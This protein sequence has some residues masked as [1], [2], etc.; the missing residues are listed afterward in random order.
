MANP[1]HPI[2]VT[3]DL[4]GVHY[5]TVPSFKT[6]MAFLRGRGTLPQIVNEIKPYMPPTG[7]YNRG[8]ARLSY[9]VHRYRPFYPDG[10]SG[11]KKFKETG[12]LYSR[13]LLFAALSGREIDKHEMTKRSLLKAGY[14]DYI[15]EWMLNKG[16]SATAWKE[17]QIR[18]KVNEG[19]TVVHLEDDT[20]TACCVA[21]VND[22]FAGETRVIVY[23]LSNLT[24]KPWLLRKAGIKL[25][26]NIILVNNLYEASEHFEK[27]VSTGVI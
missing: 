4:D 17:K 21:R 18:T 15:T 5:V 13:T 9:I 24:N 26:S 11:L 20:K 14:G 3:N 25:P 23:L 22:E 27:L 1:E 2:L 10:L 16:T 12:K 8:L 7:I 6:T 19:Y